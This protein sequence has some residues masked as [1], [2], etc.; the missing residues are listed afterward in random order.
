MVTT[1]MPILI[2]GLGI[3]DIET[4]CKAIKCAVIS[5]FLNDLQQKVWAEIMLWHLN[6]F[7]NAKHGINLFKTYISNTEEQNS[8]REI[9]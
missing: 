6:R 2:G 4:Q 7:R 5:K 8:S 3:I 9:S 1:T